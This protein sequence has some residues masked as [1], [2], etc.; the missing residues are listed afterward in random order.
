MANQAVARYLTAT[1]FR[2]D[3]RADGVA[4]YRRAIPLSRIGAHSTA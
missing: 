1:G 2:F 3:D 4:V